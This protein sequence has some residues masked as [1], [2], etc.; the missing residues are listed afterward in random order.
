MYSIEKSNDHI[1]LI[2]QKHYLTDND[3]HGSEVLSM[4]LT[5]F[6]SSPILGIDIRK[7]YI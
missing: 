7:I 3:V 4:R 2:Q 1:S 6:K 5:E